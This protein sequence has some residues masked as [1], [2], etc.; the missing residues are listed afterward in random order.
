VA[1]FFI[2]GAGVAKADIQIEPISAL[3]GPPGSPDSTFEQFYPNEFDIVHQ[4]LLTFSGTLQNLST[5]QPAFVDLS[6]DWIDPIN[7]PTPTTQFSQVFP[8]NLAPGQL[9]TIPATNP[10]TFTIPFCPPEVS[11]HIQNNGPG[12]P[13]AIEGTFTHECLRP[14]VPEPAMLLIFPALLLMGPLA[15]KG[16]KTL[17]RGV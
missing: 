13:V 10:I 7:F 9:L 15:Y 17:A 3:L 12:F 2:V 14:P 1:C 5:F 4:K 16:V 8:I 11:I 6:F